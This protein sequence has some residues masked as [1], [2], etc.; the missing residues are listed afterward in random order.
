MQL[1]RNFIILCG[2]GCLL[3]ILLFA[4]RY[5]KEAYAANILTCSVVKTW[6]PDSKQVDIYLTKEGNATPTGAREGYV[7]NDPPVDPFASAY[8]EDQL[9]PRHIVM[10]VISQPPS[11]TYTSQQGFFEMPTLSCDTSLSCPTSCVPVWN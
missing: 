3:F 10:Q 2:V 4:A 8:P 7:F 11:S 9:N 1:G 6:G 5:N